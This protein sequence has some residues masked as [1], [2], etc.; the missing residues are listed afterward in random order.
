MLK[1]E[2]KKYFHVEDNKIK[3]SLYLINCGEDLGMHLHE[4]LGSNLDECVLMYVMC[5][6]IDASCIN[7]IYKTCMMVVNIF[8]TFCLKY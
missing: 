3:F 8:K 7:M 1:F 2:F 4:V 5:I 6:Y